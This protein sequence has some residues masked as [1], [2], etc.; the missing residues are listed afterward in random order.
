MRQMIVWIIGLI[1][2]II[3]ERSEKVSDLSDKNCKKSDRF[4]I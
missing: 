1:Y 4:V 3:H 2:M